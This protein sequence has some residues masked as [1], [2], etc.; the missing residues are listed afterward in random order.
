M[1]AE[2]AE[3][4][5]RYRAELAA[6]EAKAVEDVRTLQASVDACKQELSQSNSEIASLRSKLQQTELA[7]ARSEAV[8]SSAFLDLTAPITDAHSFSVYCSFRQRGISVCNH[9]KVDVY[10][11]T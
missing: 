4:A 5:L 2:C 10:V 7:K 1:K 6:V 11:R 3:S 8:S 9:T